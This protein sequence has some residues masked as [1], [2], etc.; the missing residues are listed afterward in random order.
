MP[1]TR[2]TRKRLQPWTSFEKRAVVETGSPL[3]QERDWQHQSAPDFFS[4][5]VEANHLRQWA[6]EEIDAILQR[7]P[8][9]LRVRA[10]T[11]PV[12]FEAVPSAELQSDGIAADTLGLFV[13]P[14]YG[15]EQLSSSPIPPQ[16]I[17]FLENLWDFAEQDEEIFRE[18]V[19]TTFLHELGHYL[20]L[21]QKD[22][23]GRGLGC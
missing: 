7:L 19:H 6:T 22:L 18:E 13:G 12:T 16:I 20:G 4:Y 1:P 17:L 21:D 3:H 23:F 10:Q 2:A 8:A 5:T 11:L 15:D 14:D 9:P